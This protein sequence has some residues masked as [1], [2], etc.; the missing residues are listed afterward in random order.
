MSDNKNRS[1]ANDMALQLAHS[2]TGGDQVLA[3]EHAYHGTV[4]STV[5]ISQHKWK[6]DDKMRSKN[7]HLVSVLIL[8]A[9]NEN[10]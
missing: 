4:I 1:E 6:V 5:G 9:I 2:F 8:K 10:M 7:L 3:L